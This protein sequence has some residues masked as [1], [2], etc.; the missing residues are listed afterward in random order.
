MLGRI[1]GK[2][3]EIFARAVK[4][5][6]ADCLVTLPGLLARDGEDSLHFWFA[7]FDGLRREMFP[8]LVAA[9]AIRVMRSGIPS[10]DGADGTA[11]AAAAEVG[12]E[13]FAALAKRLLEMDESAIEALSHEVGTIAL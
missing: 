1:G 6:L 5:N 3:A 11:I 2:R 4:D 7:T 9:Y 12:S 10:R 8:R 13:H